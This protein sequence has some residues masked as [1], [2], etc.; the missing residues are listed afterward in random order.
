MRR[1]GL[2]LL[3]LFASGCRAAVTRTDALRPVALIALPGVTGRID[4]LALD[5]AHHRLFVAALGNNTVEVIDLDTG[6]V[7]A[8]IT[9]LSE[10]Q[11]V[12]YLPQQNQLYVTNGGAASLGIYDATS[13]APAGQIAL[14]EDPD[15]IRYDA[16]AD[17]VYVGHGTGAS[18]ALAV[19][20][21][22]AGTKVAD[23]P[24]PGH[25]ESFQLESNGPRIFV[26]VPSARQVTVVDRDKQEVVAT[27]PLT[28][29]RDNFPMALDEANGRL[30]VGPRSPA[31]LVV[32]DTTTGQTVARLD[33]TGDTDDIFYDPQ[34]RR[35]YVS[36]GEGRVTVIEQRDADTYRLLGAV[37]TAPGAR[38]AL[39]APESQR[40]YVAIPRRGRQEAAIQVLESP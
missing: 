10:P 23:I 8:N 30:F 40:L 36:G 1:L 6:R 35:I 39:F 9:G 7:E 15:N 13:L 16:G 26:N 5:P 20:D 14:R 19:I 27:W 28:D 34:T 25:P 24:L 32:L 38:T 22:Q 37:P 31:K 18:G 21:P 33:I 2:L 17:R 29:A 4:H 11:G 12:L 3:T